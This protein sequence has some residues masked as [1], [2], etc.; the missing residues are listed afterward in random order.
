M[1]RPGYPSYNFGGKSVF[2]KVFLLPPTRI[3]VK[4]VFFLFIGVVN[5]LQI[6]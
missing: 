4:S 3:S 6:S 2:G 5:N 1:G